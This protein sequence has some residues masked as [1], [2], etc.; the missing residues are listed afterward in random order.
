MKPLEFWYE[1]AST[2]SYPAAHRIEAVATSAGIPVRWR[3]FL[4]GPIFSALGWSTSPF[5]LQAAKGHYMWRDMERTCDRLG[6]PF[7]RPEPFP[8]NGV[9]AARIA[10]ALPD[11]GQRARFS[12]AVYVAEF[13]EGA[14]ISDPEVMARLMAREGLDG[15]ALLKRAIAPETKEALRRATQT[16]KDLGMFGAPM[17]RTADG[18]LFWGN[19]R[20]EEAVVWALNHP[21]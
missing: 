20:I 13:D 8:Q 14:T 18:E 10:L 11:D 9:L 1:F 2:Y 3:P 5:N 16:A 4:L 6:L 15:A 21:E 7:R 17:L 12:R 19:D